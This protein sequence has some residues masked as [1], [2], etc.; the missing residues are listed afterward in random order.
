MEDLRSDTAGLAH[1]GLDAAGDQ[2]H[3][4][5]S[6]LQLLSY[7]GHR[8]G[9]DLG[10]GSVQLLNEVGLD[11]VGSALSVLRGERSVLDVGGELF[12][13][14]CSGSRYQALVQTLGKKLFG[15][16]RREGERVLD[17]NE[18][19]DLTW[20]PA[21]S[22]S[23]GT[24][25]TGLFHVGGVLAYGDPLFR[26]LPEICFFDRFTERGIPVYAMELKGDRHAL[27]YRD[28]TLEKVI[29]SVERFS[30]VAFEHNERNKLIL[31]GYCGLAPQALAFVAARPQEAD[32]RFRV[33]ASF[34]GPF[35][36][37][38]CGE[39]AEIMG[40]MPESLLRASRAATVRAHDYVGGDSLRFTQDVALRSLLGKTL[41]GRFAS[42]W[43]R[44]DFARVD[45]VESLTSAQR[46]ELAGAY[47]TSPENCR[48][49]PIP[50]DLSAFSE[51]LFTRGVGERGELPASYRGRPLSL[52]SAAE[53]T[54]LRFV[55]FY[56]AQDS[57]VPGSTAKVLMQVF[58]ERYSHV[59]NE[60][61]GH[62]AYVL[63]PKM[64]ERGAPKCFDPNPV[65]LLL[66]LVGETEKHES[67]RATPSN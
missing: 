1:V 49:F 2:A 35:D 11:A 4:G 9:G 61:A 59:V 28:L 32:A 46:K 45:G 58:G 53:K 24:A 64:W 6:Y 37:R 54:Q 13:R 17:G 15:S 30:R 18:Y 22:A 63:S 48:R 20:F 56:G 67:P 39:L 44:P 16:A 55:G 14:S 23:P 47:W 40:L 19:F 41:L 51:A 5:R 42:G 10:V 36:G 31:E 27:D 8:V 38:V 26:L 3:D 57:L 66:A 52:A 43:R 29:D 25:R 50:A 65:D 60:N 62:V 7:L 12:A 21:S 34:V 33:A